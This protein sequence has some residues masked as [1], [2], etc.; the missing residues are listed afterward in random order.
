MR[1]DWINQ[2]PSLMEGH[3]EAPPEG[4]WDAVQAGVN[5]PKLVWWPWAAGLAA[6]AAAVVLAVFLWKPVQPVLPLDSTART[7]VAPT[8]SDNPVPFDIPE[9]QMAEVRSPEQPTTQVHLEPETHP[10]SQ[11]SAPRVHQEPEMHLDA[12][13]SAPEVQQEPETHLEPETHSE[14]V[15]ETVQEP[16]VWPRETVKPKRK[17]GRVQITVTS[18]GVL[19]AQGPTSVSQGYGVPYNPGMDSP[20]PMVKSG[21]TTQMLSRNRESTTTANHR[22]MP[23]VSLGVN[24]GFASRWSIGTGLTYSALRSDY[25]TLSGTTE[26]QTTRYLHYLGIPLNLQYQL[27]EWKKLSLYLIGGPMVETAVAARVDTRSYV[28]GGL[29]SEQRENPAC[30][31][32][33]WSLNAGTGVQLQLFRYGSLFVQPGFSWHI[34]KNGGVESAYTARPFSFEMDFGLRWSF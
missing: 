6:A 3:K 33:R 15:P 8:S 5:R 20:A 13:E 12:Q 29:A 10:E 2:L 25:T 30:R 23:R 34:P 7:E 16:L 14:T 26:T 9:E 11:I 27:L 18:G 31:D 21:I 22:R 19:L 4:L 17:A 32:W 28:S 24:Y 1:E